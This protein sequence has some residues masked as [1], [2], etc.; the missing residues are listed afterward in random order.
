MSPQIAIW[1]LNFGGLQQALQRP[2]VLTYL[3][4]GGF[5]EAKSGS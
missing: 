4:S 3:S 1:L 5:Q 2:P